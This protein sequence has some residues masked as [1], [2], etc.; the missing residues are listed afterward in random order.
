MVQIKH[1]WTYEPAY[2]PEW[3]LTMQRYAEKI[4]NSHVLLYSPA[5]GYIFLLIHDN[6]KP[7]IT[8]NIENLIETK[9][10]QLIDR[11]TCSTI[12]NLIDQITE[13]MID[14]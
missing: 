9:T 6:N 4:I 13:T 7:H 3:H 11:P 12:I 1:M 8:Q 2:Y 5:I 10:L 14:D